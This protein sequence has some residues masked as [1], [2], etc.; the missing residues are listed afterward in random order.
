MKQAISGA[1]HGPVECVCISYASA[2]VPYN[3]TYKTVRATRY[4]SASTTQLILGTH[5]LLIAK[6]DTSLIFIFVKVCLLS[7][8][9]SLTVDV[10]MRVPTARISNNSIAAAGTSMVTP[11]VDYLL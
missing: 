1:E 2:F 5:D 7:A 4:M 9:S 11:I 6:I 8:G 3:Y 10:S